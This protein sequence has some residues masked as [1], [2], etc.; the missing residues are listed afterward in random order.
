MCKD[1]EQDDLHRIIDSE[2][3]ERLRKVCSPRHRKPV[4]DLIAENDEPDQKPRTQ[5]MH[6]DAQTGTAAE[7]AANSWNLQHPV[8]RDLDSGEYPKDPPP[9][10]QVQRL[11]MPDGDKGEHNGDIDTLA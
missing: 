3:E 4:P 6:A 8:A 9:Q 5:I 1:A 10:K 7:Q 11:V 2:I